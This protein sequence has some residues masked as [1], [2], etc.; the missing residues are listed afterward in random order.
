M[1][2]ASGNRIFANQTGQ[3]INGNIGA[4]SKSRWSSKEWKETNP[5]KTNQGTD[6]VKRL[7]LWVK[8]IPMGISES[9]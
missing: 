7:L 8:I 6:K 9:C 4:S 2:V 1:K 5:F 3:Y